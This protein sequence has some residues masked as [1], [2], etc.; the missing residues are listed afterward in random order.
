MFADFSKRPLVLLELIAW[1]MGG[2]S[3]AFYITQGT[4]Q[5]HSA[6][7]GLA[8][9]ASARTMITSDVSS[10]Q[11]EIGAL[12]TTAWSPQRV[13][14]YERSVGT[15]GLPIAVLRIPATKLNVPI[16]EGTSDE[17]L[18][19]GAGHIEGTA[20][21]NEHGNSGVAAHRDSFF[22]LLKD[23]AVGDVIVLETVNATEHYRVSKTWIVTPTD[24]SVL[25][26]TNSPAL[27]LVTCY[28]F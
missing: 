4:R 6:G 18:Q 12:N 9:F 7:E 24:V 11:L 26:A 20:R 15:A 21:P 3:I 28:P 14:E 8:Y 22:R 1:T 25:S 19:R 17:I 16:Y 10:K 27:T 5:E 23:I 2:G 13:K